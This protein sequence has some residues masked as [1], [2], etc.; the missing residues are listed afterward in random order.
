MILDTDTVYRI[1]AIEDNADVLSNLVVAQV[2]EVITRQ[3]QCHAESCEVTDVKLCPSSTL[4]VQCKRASSSNGKCQNPV[5]V[6]PL[7]MVGGREFRCCSIVVHLGAS[8]QAGH[9]VV[10]SCDATSGV[11]EFG[12]NDE[13][14]VT[15]TQA[16][17]AHLKENWVLA[18]YAG[19]NARLTN[20]IRGFDLCCDSMPD[21]EVVQPHKAP[22]CQTTSPQDLDDTL[23]HDVTAPISECLVQGPPLNGTPQATAS[24]C[25]GTANL[26]SL[27]V[28]VGVLEAAVLELQ[29]MYQRREA[30]MLND[31]NARN[32]DSDVIATGLGV[33]NLVGAGSPFAAT[34]SASQDNS[35][36][37]HRAVLSEESPRPAPVLDPEPADQL[38]LPKST[39]Q[40]AQ[41]CRDVPGQF[42]RSTNPQVTEVVAKLRTAG[43]PDTAWLVERMHADALLLP[44]VCLAHDAPYWRK[45]GET[46][47]YSKR[48]VQSHVAEDNIGDDAIQWVVVRM[49]ARSRYN[50][51]ADLRGTNDWEN[52]RAHLCQLNVPNWWRKPWTK[53]ESTNAETASRGRRPL[54]PNEW[55]R[56]P[57]SQRPHGPGRHLSCYR[58]L[59]GL[60]HN[61][62]CPTSRSRS[63][64]R[65]TVSAS[66]VQSK[67]APLPNE[68]NE[69]SAEL[70]ACAR[71]VT[72]ADKPSR[73]RRRKTK[74]APDLKGGD[75]S[76][77]NSSP[78]RVMVAN[79]TSLFSRVAAVCAI[80]FSVAFLSETSLTPHGQDTLTRQ[81]FQAGRCVV[82]G[83]PLDGPGVTSSCGVA[84]V[85]GPG[86]RLQHLQVPDSLHDAWAQ[87]RVVAGIASV[88]VKGGAQ[89]VTCIACYGHVHD[90]PAREQLLTHIAEWILTLRGHVLLG[91]D[92]NTDLHDS[93]ALLCLMQRGYRTVNEEREITCLAPDAERGTVID[94]LLVSASLWPA[95]V[96]HNV[97][98]EAP[99]PTHKPIMAGFDAK[100]V[101]DS[102][103]TLQQPRPF[104]IQGCTPTID[105]QLVYQNDLCRIGALTR[106]GHHGA[107]YEAWTQ[108][109]ERELMHQCRRGAKQV[110]NM[111]F[112]R[113]I[114]PKLRH[115]QLN[116][117]NTGVR[118]DASHR[119]LEKAR[120]GL[121]ELHARWEACARANTQH[122]LWANA[123]RRMLL[124]DSSLRDLP[125]NLPDQ[126]VV[127]EWLNWVRN[128]ID[129]RNKRHRHHAIHDW[130]E[131]L[132]YSQADR[133]VWAKAKYAKWQSIHDTRSCFKEIE[134]HWNPILRR[135]VS[136]SRVSGQGVHDGQSAHESL[137]GIDLMRITGAQL[138]DAL[139]QSPCRSASGADGWRR[140]ELLALPCPL[141]DS[142]AEVLYGMANSGSWHPCL[143]TV[144]TTLIPKKDTTTNPTNLRPISVASLVYRSWAKVLA[145]RLHA[146][147]ECSL[148]SSAH[149]FRKGESAQSTMAWIFLKCQNA[150]LSGR[151]LHIL[152]YDV[153]KCFDSLPWEDVRNSLVAC[154]V[155]PS[156]ARAL[157]SHWSTLRRIWKIQGRYQACSFAARNGLM[158]GD[159]VAPACLA[160]FLAEPV[161]H[162]ELSWPAVVVSQYADDIVLLSHDAGS[163]ENANAYL[164][165]WMQQKNIELNAGKCH[166]ACTSVDAAPARIWVNGR[167]LPRSRLLENL[168]GS[169]QLD[170][171]GLPVA[172]KTHQS[173]VFD[174]FVSVAQRLGRLSV[175]W[176][177]RAADVRA[178][179]PMLTYCAMTWDPRDFSDARKQRFLVN[180]LSGG[181][182]NNRR[183]TEISL[184][185][186]SAVHHT[187]IPAALVHEQILTLGRI[188]NVNALFRQEVQDHFAICR[189][190]E[191]LPPESFY[192][193][194]QRS[195]HEYGWHWADWD[196]LQ[197]PDGTCF[198]LSGLT[199]E[200]RR[201]E[202]N[203]EMLRAS[204][205]DDLTQAVQSMSAAHRV[206]SLTWP[207]LLH[208]LRCAMRERLCTQAA[209]RRRDM[210]GLE[211]V[212]R[213]LLRGLWKVIPQ[214]DHPTLRFLMQGA[215][216]TAGREHR[217]S[218]GRL[219]PICR[220]CDLGVGED[221]KHRYWVCPRWEAVRREHLG[222]GFLDVCT[223]LTGM[224]NVA[225]MCAVPVRQMPP[226]IRDRW[227]RIC[228]C[229]I[230]IHRGAAAAHGS[231]DD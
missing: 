136:E 125:L 78:F 217:S 98:S 153:T 199:L 166:Y 159:P 182:I 210:R 162:I 221:E 49:L 69:R 117:L 87:G 58:P 170:G 140:A 5:D 32:R 88:S 209:R 215:V 196:K 116:G 216:M 6:P 61:Q 197:G 101:N 191:A 187:N 2:G 21:A 33:N 56:K 133:F 81:L 71:P 130:R 53:L 103:C 124:V 127:H 17:L 119:R 57:Y 36:I 67:P 120:S 192:A 180:I 23:P 41:R 84:L 38:P 48:E 12:I 128:E 206:H 10:V 146:L 64:L 110:T 135:P 126:D 34:N 168:G 114:P 9:Y 172:D 149:G 219:S 204:T 95:I 132:K 37:E 29:S 121:A 181:K 220:F 200:A 25:M 35:R 211:D 225:S 230:A 59:P 118:E 176:D 156:T 60:A 129:R 82:W 148:P 164:N 227:P 93:P 45:L 68:P 112:G 150:A 193:C 92:F 160:A 70:C 188:L 11:P 28:R 222:D 203:A 50:R 142:L 171:V 1:S 99:W 16:N 214:E 158:Q 123:R 228:S 76:S 179:M 173:E 94:H 96:S 165:E 108:L 198:L 55:R 77:C 161:H 24:A 152:S 144:V 202:A 102:W 46:L 79:V 31:P 86:N 20:P 22:D 3:C 157:H 97:M 4:L 194:F 131:R 122:A 75:G 143:K 201:V 91:G 229:M 44:M 137:S 224:P 207:E 27:A 89:A 186:L 66:N 223:L 85:G 63:P 105:A 39:S 30:P 184:G 51:F 73:R 154:G 106:E 145:K 8:A 151:P 185:V 74:Q 155:H 52:L 178:I 195:L 100:A 208:S 104:P 18:L 40:H 13:A 62:G 15:L 189:S 218:R 107:A 177:I 134:A 226:E 169:F 54:L 26:E 90:E 80:A 111:H 115:C 139:Q 183:C 14:R 19:P 138:R 174:K 43:H 231:P 205:A 141:W 190:M 113:S 72:Q 163:L 167:K 212:D 147:L 175:G 42:P 7:L 47:A 65:Q 213:E 83:N 109:A